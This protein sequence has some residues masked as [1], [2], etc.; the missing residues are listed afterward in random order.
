[1]LFRFGGELE[2][3][4]LDDG[5]SDWLDRFGGDGVRYRSLRDGLDERFE[6]RLELRIRHYIDLAA[7]AADQPIAFVSRLLALLFAHY[8][9]RHIRVMLM[10]RYRSDILG[11]VLGHELSDLQS[12]AGS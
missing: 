1:M 6:V 12:S 11:N 10:S 3:F 5:L 8:E 2:L 7:F 9:H 4:R